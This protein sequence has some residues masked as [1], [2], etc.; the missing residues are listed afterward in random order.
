MNEPIAKKIIEEVVLEKHRFSVMGE[1]HLPSRIDTSSHE[2]RVLVERNG[3]N[4]L[5][6]LSAYIYGTV[7]EKVSYSFPKTWLDAFKLRWFPEWAI[8]RW[9]PIVEHV[10]MNKFGLY[11]EIP[12]RNSKGAMLVIPFVEL[13][14]Y[15]DMWDR[16]DDKSKLRGVK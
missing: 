11:P 15:V 5:A 4:L 13:N 8:R 12:S 7:P 6:N 14:K 16:W 2:Y 3:A 9:P 1:I 10:E